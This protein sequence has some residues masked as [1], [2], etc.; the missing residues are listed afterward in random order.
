M[1]DE[2]LRSGMFRKVERNI[3]TT[4]KRIQALI[5]QSVELGKSIK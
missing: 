2:K 4:N 5:I 3:N 1:G